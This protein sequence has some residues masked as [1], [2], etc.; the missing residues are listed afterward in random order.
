MNHLSKKAR[1]SSVRR[2]EKMIRA[3]ARIAK[4]S[5]KAGQR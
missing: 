3:L 2:A 4:K 5:A 1:K